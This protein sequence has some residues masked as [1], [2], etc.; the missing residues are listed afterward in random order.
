MKHS[1][2]TLVN[3]V[4][5]EQR[6][7]LRL[8]IYDNGTVPPLSSTSSDGL[9]LSNMKMRTQQLNGQLIVEYQDGFKVELLLK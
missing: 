8:L 3:I 1:D 9:G 4:F 6:N 5:S 7:Q 2:A